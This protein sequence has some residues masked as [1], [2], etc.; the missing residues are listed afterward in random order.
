MKNKL[1]FVIVGPQRTGSSWLDRALRDHPDI[2]MPNLS[3]E[4]FF[5]D[6]PANGSLTDYF[7]RYFADASAEL[8]AGEAGP[9]YFQN[10]AARDRLGDAFSD[11][12]IIILIRDPVERTF[13]LFRHEVAKGRSEDDLVQA[14]AGNPE[15]VESGRYAKHIPAWFD[16][17][18][19]K[20]I[21]LVNFEDIERRPDELVKGIQRFI[22]VSEQSLSPDL[23]DKYGAARI[24][25][26]QTIA[27]LAAAASRGLRRAGFD[28]IVELA[29]SLGLKDKIF[30]GGDASRLKISDDYRRILEKAHAEDIN[31]VRQLKREQTWSF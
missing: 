27:T 29:K 21:L 16:A 24:P 5:F 6:D 10:A 30:S 19:E 17:F 2:A 31:Y 9:T 7:N 3:K 13:S 4:T 14:M 25:R 20:N 28:R 22:G 11:L 15:I 23:F 26:V 1:D 18:G 12:K 8:Q